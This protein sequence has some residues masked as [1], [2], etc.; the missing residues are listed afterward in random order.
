MSTSAGSNQTSTFGPSHTYSPQAST[1]DMAASWAL[2]S[3]LAGLFIPVIAPIAAI[4]CAIASL[5]R[6][7]AAPEPKPGGR[8]IAIGSLIAGLIELAVVAVI[9]LILLIVAA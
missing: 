8:A 9:A 1:T 6:I 4:S 7:K 3:A 2:V 5:R